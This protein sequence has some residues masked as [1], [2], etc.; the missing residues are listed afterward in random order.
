MMNLIQSLRAI[1]QTFSF[2]RDRA[3]RIAKIGFRSGLG[4]GAWL[5]HG[6]VMSM[7]PSVCVEIGSARGCSA[8]YIGLALRQLKRGRLFA[9][10]PHT[11]TD[12]NDSH[13]VDTYEVMRR[14]LRAFHAED[15]VE[16]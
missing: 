14:S 5:L 6:L 12:W 2:K 8:C 11:T 9:I 13:S 7:K 3:L 4:R 1:A 15:Y 16:V 10:D